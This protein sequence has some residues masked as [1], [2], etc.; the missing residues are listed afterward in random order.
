MKNHEFHSHAAIAMG[1][2]GQ[3]KNGDTCSGTS[4]EWFQPLRGASD[5]I[6]L[7]KV[8]TA[9]P[10]HARLQLENNNARA[11]RFIAALF[12]SVFS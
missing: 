8:V 7:M 10:L 3:L 5:I 6:G 9:S 1:R 12:A 11:R 2:G 4:G